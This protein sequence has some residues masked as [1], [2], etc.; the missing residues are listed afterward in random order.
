[1]FFFV[2][3]KLFSPLCLRVFCSLWA[4][5]S[6]YLSYARGYFRLFVKVIAFF[7]FMLEDSLVLFVKVKIFIVFI[8]L[9]GILDFL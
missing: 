9:V 7:S 2:E 5:K 1:M 4:G 8:M 6:F 3:V